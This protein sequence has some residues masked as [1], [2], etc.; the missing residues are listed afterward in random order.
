MFWTRIH[1][2]SQTITARMALSFAV[3]SACILLVLSYGLYSLVNG[4][5]TKDDRDV[6]SDAVSLLTI[7]LREQDN[8]Q[9][10][11]NRRLPEELNA[12][13]FNRYQVRLLSHSSP[14]RVLFQSLHFPVALIPHLGETPLGKEQSCQIEGHTYL[15]LQVQGLLG[16]HNPQPILMQTALETTA[17]VNTLVRLQNSLIQLVCVGV[18]LFSL[19]GMVVVRLGL[20]PLRQFSQRIQGIRMDSLNARINIRD[21]PSELGPL[22][23][24]FNRLLGQ[25]EKDVDQ[26]T[27]FSGDLAHELRTPITNL[28]VETEVLLEKARTLDE[29]RAV[30][31]G[32]LIELERLSKVV[33]RILLL[34][35]MDSPQL[36]LEMAPCQMAPLVAKLFDFYGQLPDFCR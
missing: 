28:R 27:R 1:R 20:R 22:A 23:D 18:F 21:W 4:Q 31:E 17:R 36:A 5:L 32:N 25:L 2:L 34:A 10:L 12:F 3:A 9:F 19:L 6:L 11:L 30:L 15:I 8:N 33:D 24:S 29:Y 14:R 35:K 7:T 13:H 16:E 26:L